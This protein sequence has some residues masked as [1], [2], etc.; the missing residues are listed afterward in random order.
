MFVSNDDFPWTR[1]LEDSFLAI[2]EEY[3]ALD[4][5]RLRRWPE[6]AVYNHGWE[7]FG[8]YG[9]GWRIDENCALCPHLAS[10]LDAIPDITTAGFSVLS[11]GTIIKPH[12]GYTSSVLRCHLGLVVPGDCGLRV[13]GETRTWVEGECFIFDDTF[14]H[15][16]WNRSDRPR[17]VLLLD[18]VRPGATFDFRATP[19][20]QVFRYFDVQVPK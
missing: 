3:E 12:R 2:R 8:L 13:G 19:R 15:E 7:V 5:Q 1:R 16:A 18:V 20:A 11:P 9:F 14:E 4:R 6:T 17:V 10:V